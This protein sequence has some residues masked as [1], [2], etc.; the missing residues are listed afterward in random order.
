MI[1]RSCIIGLKSFSWQKLKGRFIFLK[2][3]ILVPRQE[4]NRAEEL[5][6]VVTIFHIGFKRCP[7][8]LNASLAFQFS[9][10]TLL[11]NGMDGCVSLG[12]LAQLA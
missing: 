1:L 4:W 3:T 10:P 7:E 6:K 5:A 11:S 9:T 2:M 12:R 8:I